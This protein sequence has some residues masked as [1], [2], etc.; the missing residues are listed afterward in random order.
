MSL[1]FHVLK[2]K[3]PCPALQPSTFMTC[4]GVSRASVTGLLKASRAEPKA[5]LDGKE[6]GSGEE[7]GVETEVGGGKRAV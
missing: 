3:D 4:L 2:Q 7:R 5:L 1:S 6:G